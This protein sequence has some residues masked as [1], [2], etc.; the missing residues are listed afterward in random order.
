[1][2]LNDLILGYTYIH[3][4]HLE[5]RLLEIWKADVYFLPSPVKK[6]FHIFIYFFLTGFIPD[7]ISCFDT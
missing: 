1:M 2:C 4:L 6:D 5:V 3:A 7:N